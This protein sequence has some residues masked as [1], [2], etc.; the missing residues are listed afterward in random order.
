MT[1]GT[2]WR[3]AALKSRR[4]WTLICHRGTSTVTCPSTI[5][6][7]ATCC[8]CTAFYVRRI[9]VA[10]PGSRYTSARLA[11]WFG[12]ANTYNTIHVSYVSPWMRTGFWAYLQ[13]HQLR[14]KARSMQLSLQL[15]RSRY[16]ASSI[17][18]AYWER[19]VK[20]ILSFK[21]KDRAEI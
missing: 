8:F 1:K 13:H 21:N 6:T 2:Y 16:W 4:P 11:G 15:L 18:Y 20:I 5:T 17:W 7:R 19:I 9:T 14:S 3:R 10:C 12:D